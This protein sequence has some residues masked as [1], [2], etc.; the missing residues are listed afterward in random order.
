MPYYQF[1]A[2]EAETG[3]ISN[4]LYGCYETFLVTKKDLEACKISMDN[5]TEAGWHWWA[6]FPGCL[7][8]GDATGP[9]KT[10][11]EAKANA[12]GNDERLV[13]PNNNAMIKRPEGFISWSTPP[14]VEG[15]S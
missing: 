4:P 3:D 12:E 1:K 2:A 5:P 9:F 15:E 11:V 6:C 13:Y 8:D 7:P 10:E 14:E